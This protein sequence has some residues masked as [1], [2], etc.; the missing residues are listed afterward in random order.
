MAQIMPVLAWDALGAAEVPVPTLTF[1]TGP[2]NVG[3]AAL[4][5]MRP[6]PVPLGSAEAEALPPPHFIDRAVV[7]LQVPRLSAEVW[8]GNEKLEE[9]GLTRY[10]ISPPLELGKPYAYDVVVRWYEDGK[11]RKRTLRINVKA[12][13][14]PVVMVLGALAK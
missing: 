14:Q 3:Y 13:E 8:V 12:G 9:G 7:A 11:E 4:N 10:F 6:P 2:T 5:G 1:Y